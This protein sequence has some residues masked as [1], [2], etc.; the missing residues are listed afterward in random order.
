M[1]YIT[2]TTDITGIDREERYESNNAGA[3]NADM[4]LAEC[5]LMG[6]NWGLQES[7][8]KYGSERDLALAIQL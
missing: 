2:L 6:V 5:Q 3:D 4:R 8:E 1:L 7:T